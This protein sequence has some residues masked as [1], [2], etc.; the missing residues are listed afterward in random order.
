MTIEDALRWAIR[1][2]LP[3]RREDS[4]IRGPR[5][6]SDPVWR[7]VAMGGRVDNWSREPG[8]PPAMGDPHPDAITIEAH[9]Q[10]LSETLQK[11]AAGSAL[12]P[13]DL[14]PYPVQ[15]GLRGKASLEAMTST[16]MHAT[17]AWLMTAAIRNRP[18]VAGGIEIEP[19]KSTNGKIT[20]WRT[21]LT[22]CG[23]GPDGKPWFTSHDEVALSKGDSRDMGLFCKLT[24]TRTGVEVLEEQLRYAYWHAALVYLV[25]ALQFLT[26][27]EVLSPRAPIAP[28]LEP[29]EEER[30]PLPNL[31]PRRHI[32]NDRRV[33]GRRA[34]PLRASPVR[35][36]DPRDWAPS[37]E[38][39]G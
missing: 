17:P 26:S 28:W 3:K 21:K 31:R 1:D 12:C 29:K 20:L 39:T 38:R 24:Y 19:V 30:A 4:P 9:L 5:C 25:P 6:A 34:A 16:A 32:E 36:I 27:I 23:E 10:V 2:E 15:V 7:M 14:T 35:K 22:P 37:S 33:A 18:E 8:M 13:L 11:A